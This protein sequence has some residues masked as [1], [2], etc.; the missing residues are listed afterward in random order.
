MTL[1]EGTRR[2]ISLAVFFLFGPVLFAALIGLLWYRRGGSLEDE[3]TALAA[4]FSAEVRLAQTEY[5]RPGV[6]IYSDFALVDSESGEP[7]L[8]APEIVSTCASKKRG[9]FDIGSSLLDGD[10]FGEDSRRGAAF[11]T[12]LDAPPDTL[13]DIPILYLKK[14]EADSIKNLFFRS[15]AKWADIAVDFHIGAIKIA[16]DEPFDQVVSHIASPSE[17]ALGPA[18]NS[19]SEFGIVDGSTEAIRGRVERFLADGLSI[20]NVRGVWRKEARESIFAMCVNPLRLPE[21]ASE[22]Q[23]LLCRNE[24]EANAPSRTLSV[25]DTFSAPF[26]TALASVFVPIF[27][28][29]DESSWFSGRLIAETSG[30]KTEWRVSH[31]ALFET[32]LATWLGPEN[33]RRLI[34]RIERLAVDEATVKEGVFL[35]RGALTIRDGAFDKPLIVRLQKELGLLFNPSHTLTNRFADDR[36]GLDRLQARFEFLPNELTVGSDYP[37]GVIG[38][39]KSKDFSCAVFLPTQNVTVPYQNILSAFSDSTLPF[40]TPFYRD[41]IQRLPVQ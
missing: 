3:R 14:S 11:R 25:F 22:T 34:G 37:S 2:K 15:G 38:M 35:G 31:F 1:T 27:R 26:P 33:R 20:E 32:E 36:V 6:K 5:R 10:L 8:F 13:W 41:A 4:C 30:A 7:F 29:S 16:D 12:M 17:N 23:W 21:T 40:W 19:V 9:R 24:P 18:E 28:S 39:F